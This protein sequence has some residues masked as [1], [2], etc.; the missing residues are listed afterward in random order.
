MNYE[1]PMESFALEWVANELSNL[2]FLLCSEK[3][4]LYKKMT[5]KILREFNRDILIQIH[6]VLAYGRAILEYAKKKAGDDIDPFEVK[7]R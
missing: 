1:N 6:R 2:I 7:Q 4:F 5:W 3:N